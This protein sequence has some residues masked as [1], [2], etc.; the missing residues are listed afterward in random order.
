[1]LSPFFLFCIWVVVASVIAFGP[2]RFHWRGAIILMLSAVPLL[3]ALYLNHGLL[4]T[5]AALAAM[6]SILRWPALFLL[7]K[8]GRVV[9][10]GK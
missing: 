8:L 6:L 3:V 1:M 4:W 7:R 5:V 9:G 10:I 2:R